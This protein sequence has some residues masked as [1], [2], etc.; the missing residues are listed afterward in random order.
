MADLYMELA[1]RKASGKFVRNGNILVHRTELNADIWR[2]SYSNTDVFM[3]VFLRTL[4]RLRAPMIAHLAFDFDGLTGD[5]NS[6]LAALEDA[7][8]ATSKVADVLI[9]DLDIPEDQVRTSFSGSKGFHL[10]LSPALFGAEPRTDLN[11]VYRVL[12]SDIARSAGVGAVFDSEIY[13]ARRVF[14]LLN[15]INSKGTA[16]LKRPVFKVPLSLMELVSEEV[17]DILALARAPRAPV[18]PD[19]ELVPVPEAVELYRWA[20]NEVEEEARRRV[21]LAQQR[22]HELP[23][24]SCGLPPCM[25]YLVEHGAP[26]GYRNNTLFQLVLFLHKRKQKSVED[27][28]AQVRGF[29]GLDDDEVKATVASGCRGPNPGE[30]YRVGCRAQ[31]TR[32]NALIRSGVTICDRERC[33]ILEGF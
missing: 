30:D 16:H 27:I 7:R 4:P 23:R 12:A 24:S 14:R 9:N 19:D 28:Y 6:W 10:L 1:A 13:D 17:E 8:V 18:M 3:G 33:F 5:D 25:A 31:E 15:S 22:G 32:L 26:Q 2:R 11:Q 20:C 21:E 29:A